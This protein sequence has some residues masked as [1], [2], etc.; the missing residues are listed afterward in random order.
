MYRIEVLKLVA[1]VLPLVALFQIFDG[2]AAIAN[3]ILSAQGKQVSFQ[4]FLP[5]EVFSTC[6]AGYWC[7][8]KS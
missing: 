3:G 1:G 2:V 7:Y 4:I 8:V 6:N 5:L